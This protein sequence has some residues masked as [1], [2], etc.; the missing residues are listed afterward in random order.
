MSKTKNTSD[1]QKMLDD[2]E[3]SASFHYEEQQAERTALF[4]ALADESTFTDPESRE[5]AKH[6]VEILKDIAEDSPED[7]QK[8]LNSMVNDIK[9]SP[10][11]IDMK[12]A[13]V[14]YDKAVIELDIAMDNYT[15][16]L[17]NLKKF[18]GEE[19]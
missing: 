17:A 19:E 18:L 3:L 13:T 6:M 9:G 10:E 11:A 15:T 4:D 12:N 14:A 5:M 1:F 16:A 7:A 2:M 8:L